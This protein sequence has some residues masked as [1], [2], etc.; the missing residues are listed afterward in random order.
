[1][2]TLRPKARPSNEDSF[3]RLESNIREMADEL[4]M[5]RVALRAIKQ[6]LNS[7]PEKCPRPTKTILSLIEE[8]L[9]E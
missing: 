9:G 2:P 6:V 8:G 5:A 1:M 3:D 4:Q 7:P